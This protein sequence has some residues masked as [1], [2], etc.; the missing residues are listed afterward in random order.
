MRRHEGSKFLKTVVSVYQCNDC[1]GR[2]TTLQN[3]RDNMWSRRF[4]RVVKRKSCETYWIPLGRLMTTHV[5]FEVTFTSTLTVTNWAA[6]RSF[7]SVNMLIH[8][9]EVIPCPVPEPDNCFALFYFVINAC[10]SHVI[11]TLIRYFLIPK[12][13]DLVSHNPGI[14]GLKNGPGSGIAIPKFISFV[15]NMNLLMHNCI[16]MK[17]TIREQVLWLSSQ[18][19][20]CSALYEVVRRIRCV[21][22]MRIHGAI[23]YVSLTC[24]CFCKKWSFAKNAKNRP[25]TPIFP[26][27]RIILVLDAT[28]AP[29]F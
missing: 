20:Q 12:S 28:F 2:F 13:R 11:L 6:Q 8:T 26:P 22:V 9:G 24:K 7:T 25:K 23:A 10:I 29:K 4:C 14:S 21:C 3:L 17:N 18:G 16:I 1:N 27:L 19:P 5:S 15:L